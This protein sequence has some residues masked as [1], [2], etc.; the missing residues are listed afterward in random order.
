[1][2]DINQFLGAWI[3]A[4]IALG[5]IIFS[6]IQSIIN[7]IANAVVTKS[8]NKAKLELSKLQ[9]DNEKEQRNFEKAQQIR[10]VFSEYCG[11]TASVINSNGELNREKQAAAFGNVILYLSS[12]Q[13]V[14]SGIQEDI[15]RND[16]KNAQL[17]FSRILKT[18]K[19]EETLL[20]SQLEQHSPKGCKDD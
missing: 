14:I 20:L 10:K 15:N 9:F 11:L 13:K 8:N 1:M 17:N 3:T 4:G 7:A 12:S 2:K 5:G 16:F 18:L 19:E 6:V